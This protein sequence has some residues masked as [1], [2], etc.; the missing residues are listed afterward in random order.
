MKY[1]WLCALAIGC[2]GGSSGGEPQLGDATL[3]WGPSPK[4][5]ATGA[6]IMDPKNA[7]KM[8][9]QL[10][11]DHVSCSTDLDKNLPPQGDYVYFSTAPATGADPNAT[12]TVIHYAGSHINLDIT[13]GQS[14]ID[15]VSDRV[16]GTIT[17]STTDSDA[18][19]PDTVT[20]TGS[21]D[22]KKC[23]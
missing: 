1:A 5:M 23:F 2:S 6:A 16:M 19:T 14:Q 22:V 8:R 21:F 12:V 11:A 10:G 4:M 3:Q 17:F 20:M 15:A 18:G 13:G 7:G 9:I